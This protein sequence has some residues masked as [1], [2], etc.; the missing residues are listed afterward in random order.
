MRQ[1]LSSTFF[2]LTLKTALQHRYSKCLCFIIEVPEAN[3]DQVTCQDDRLELL[4][5][6]FKSRCPAASLIAHSH[7]TE[8]VTFLLPSTFLSFLRFESLSF[9]IPD[10]FEAYS[11]HLLNTWLPFICKII[12]VIVIFFYFFWL[13]SSHFPA[14]IL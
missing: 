5:Q 11:P 8:P 13:L 4:K 9:K 10:S 2:H 3:R 14:Y 7:S 1:A 6:G 12:P